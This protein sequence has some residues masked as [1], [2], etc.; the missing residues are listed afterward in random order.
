MSIDTRIPLMAAQAGQVNL[1]DMYQQQQAMQMQRQQMDMQREEMEFRKAVQAANIDKA[2][3]EAMK[4]GVKDMAAAVRW[5]D[6]PE[7]W[8]QVQ[9][10]YAQYDPQLASVPFEQREGALLKLGQLGEYLEKTQEKFQAIEPGGSLYGISPDGNVREVVRANPGGAA[11]ASP[12]G[13]V[14]EGATATNP[15]TGEKIIYRNGRWEP[16]GGTAGNGG[17]NFPPVQ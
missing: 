11:P 13:S 15:Q 10:H 1:V 3:A 17:G 12:V 6:T 16:M 5:A 4:E 14:Q 2:K 8:A 9:Q 7:K